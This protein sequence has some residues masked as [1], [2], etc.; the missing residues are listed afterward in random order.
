[1]S[2]GKYK[3]WAHIQMLTLVHFYIVDVLHARK[4]VADYVSARS[5][6][7]GGTV[8]GRVIQTANGDVGYHVIIKDPDSQPKFDE[9]EV[10]GFTTDDTGQTVLFKLTLENAHEAYLKGVVTRSQWIEAKVPQSDKGKRKV[11]ARKHQCQGMNLTS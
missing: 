9:G 2:I 8:F 11:I 7:I 1:M 10:I 3:A 5:A 6:N 4:V